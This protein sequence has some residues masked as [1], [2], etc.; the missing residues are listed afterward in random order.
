MFSFGRLAV[1]IFTLKVTFSEISSSET[2]NKTK[3]IF[4]IGETGVVPCHFPNISANFHKISRI[5]F[6]KAGV[7]NIYT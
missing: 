1:I 5:K 2:H 4:D 6:F 7:K 3:N